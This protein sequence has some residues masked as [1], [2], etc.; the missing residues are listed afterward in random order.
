MSVDKT[1]QPTYA[2]GKNAAWDNIE[3]TK[4][5]ANLTRQAAAVCHG[6]LALRSK[7]SRHTILKVAALKS[8]RGT[9]KGLVVY[10][11]NAREQWDISE[12]AVRW[13][14][15]IKMNDEE[16]GLVQARID[17]MMDD[18][19]WPR[20]TDDYLREREQLKREYD[21]KQKS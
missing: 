6:T 7:A 2:I 13:A 14:H 1:G 11:V 21:E 16:D 20:T 10:D 4:G 17:N 12:D 3:W 19:P 5:L 18:D 8:V 9:D 15:W